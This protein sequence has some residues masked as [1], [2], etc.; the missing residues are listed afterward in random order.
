MA[1][2]TLG[3]W[4]IR[5]LGN[6]IRLL[7]EYAGA[8]YVEKL[9]KCGPPPEFERNEWLQ[10][11]ANLGIKCAN[12]PYIIDGDVK[13]AQSG[14][15][16]RY[17]GRKFNLVGKT[18]SEQ[19]DVELMADQVRDYFM[20]YVAIVYNP[21]FLKVKEEYL[22]NLSGN[23]QQLS[24]MIEGRKFVA[25][26]YVTY[27]DFILF[28]FLDS[29]L[30][31]VPGLLKDYPVLEEYH[32]RVMSLEPIDKYLKSPKAIKYPFFGAP[33]YFGGHYSDILLKK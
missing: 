16:M 12:L 23:L 21:E 2:L 22:K 28:E 13:I 31:L 17:L 3:Y 32:K 30:Y 4:D 15:I 19:L 25:G 18:E 8:E 29:Q 1:P 10:D 6:P 33:S 7:L 5:G 24:K 26:D 11:K 20:Q 9:Y 27:V 14:V